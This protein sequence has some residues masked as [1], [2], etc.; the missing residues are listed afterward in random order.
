MEVIYRQ[1]ENYD[2]STELNKKL[3]KYKAENKLT[4]AKIS[5]M[6]DITDRALRKIRSGKCKPTFMVIIKIAK[7][8]NLKIEELCDFIYDKESLGNSNK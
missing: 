3:N 6:C 4:W 5:I 2:F 7:G 8:L 1:F